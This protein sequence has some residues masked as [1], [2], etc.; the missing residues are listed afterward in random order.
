M[1]KN[2]LCFP[3]ALLVVAA[4]HT[5][6]AEEWQC[7]L[8]E[9]PPSTSTFDY[10]IV[11]ENALTARVEVTPSKLGVSPLDDAEAGT[12]FLNVLENSP[13]GLVLA[14]GNAGPTKY[15]RGV[16][17]SLLVLDRRNATAVQSY[18]MATEKIGYVNPPRMGSCT[19][20]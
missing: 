11:L 8:H 17:G 20:R 4:C 12:S 13:D 1:T 10:D 19:R 14:A 6:N 15:G 7:Q 5:A 16:Y 9:I 18:A 3:A 2:A